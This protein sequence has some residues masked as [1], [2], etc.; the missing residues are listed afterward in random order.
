VN[1]E[2]RTTLAILTIAV[3]SL[4][5]AGVFEPRMGVEAK[6]SEQ[7]QY[8]LE[9][10]SSW[11]LRFAAWLPAEAPPQHAACRPHAAAQSVTPWGLP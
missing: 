11:L 9:D 3:L 10:V 5:L 6:A 8:V 2:K 1:S 7:P 4:I